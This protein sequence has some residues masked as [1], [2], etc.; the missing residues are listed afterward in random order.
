MGTETSS[1]GATG[2]AQTFD[3]AQAAFATAHIA[4][5]PD[6]CADPITRTVMSDQNPFA[7]KVASYG[8]A[9]KTTLEDHR[10]FSGSVIGQLD[11]AFH[12]IRSLPQLSPD[13]AAAE[14]DEPGIS[15]KP[16][17]WRAVREALINAIAHRDYATY[18]GSTIVNVT[19]ASVEVISLG[20]LFGGLKINDL[21]NGANQPRNIE[22]AGL[23]EQLGFV[24]NL[25]NGIQQ[26]M[27]AYDDGIDA[28]QL[29]VAPA[30]VAVILPLLRVEVP[31]IGDGGSHRGNRDASEDDG[32]SGS[33][34][35]GGDASNGT[36]DT[37]RIATKYRFPDMPQ[38]R[39][40]HRIDHNEGVDQ[41]E[42]RRTAPNAGSA[43]PATPLALAPLPAKPVTAPDAQPDT[44]QLDRSEL[45]PLVL[46][47]LIQRGIP[48]R[49]VEIQEPLHL[50]K[51]QTNYALRKLTAEGKVRRIGNS[52]ATQ[53]Q[54]IV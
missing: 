14:A 21:I 30:S 4:W 41:L 13:H 48:L 35:N 26:I 24:H 15:A 5:D 7:L 50:T 33:G 25:G 38:G 17:P 27:Q 53:Y 43:T 46:A 54:A 2:G 42:L 40:T 49:R 9:D 36:G 37:G 31:D 11:G 23:L 47:Y 3:A 34:V 52:R 44:G 20:G 22:L 19:P 28:P 1:A 8:D 10:N 6:S 45:E 12:Y 29:R 18:T 32:R 16:V 39:L 51:N